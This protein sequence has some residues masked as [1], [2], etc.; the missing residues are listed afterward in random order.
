MAL[1]INVVR[2]TPLALHRATLL[3]FLAK[4]PLAS[5][6][7]MAHPL[8]I[9][10]PLHLSEG[11]LTYRVKLRHRPEVSVTGCAYLL[12]LKSFQEIDTDRF[13]VA[14]YG[15]LQSLLF[16]Q[17][18]ESI[19]EE[20][21][22]IRLVD[23]N[24][25]IEWHALAAYAEYALSHLPFTVG[26][27]VSDGAFHVHLQPVAEL[28]AA[29]ISLHLT[30]AD[31]AKDVAGMFQRQGHFLAQE[32]LKD[33]FLANLADVL[34]ALT[35][36]EKAAAILHNQ[37]LLAEQAEPTP[38]RTIS[39]CMIV[40]NEAEHL[41]ACLASV[42]G[43]VDEIIVVDTGSTD[44]TIQIAQ[45]FGAKVIEVPWQEDFAAARNVSL[46]HATSDWILVLDADEKLTCHH[47]ILRRLTTATGQ[48]IHPFAFNVQINNLDKAGTFEGITSH[49]AP[50]LFKRSFGLQY[51]GIIHEQLLKDGQPILLASA[52]QLTILHTGYTQA[53]MQGK[54][55]RNLPLLSRAAQA[56]PSNPFVHFNL[57]NTYR[58][59]GRIEEAVTAYRTCLAC[60]D[61][62][63]PPHYLGQVY[64]CLSGS[65]LDQKDYAGAFGLC[66]N[67]H[68]MAHDYAEHWLHAGWACLALQMYPEAVGAFQ[69]A[70]QTKGMIGDQSASTWK[71]W[72]GL[73]Q[74]Y[75]A[76]GDKDRAL[77]ALRKA[78]GIARN[79]PDVRAAS[80]RVQRLLSAV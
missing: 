20:R 57:G 52:P 29:P 62:E 11:S 27:S 53:N 18:E 7:P 73:M 12:D 72:L 34:L 22:A 10:E 44:D 23:M 60:V 51:Q 41:P 3:S 67:A 4:E 43:V 77:V 54:Y 58:E 79:H 46:S 19:L 33:C 64:V 65:L 21:E 69:R 40:R 36:V 55:E 31:L 80:A 74:A 9:W 71:P 66:Q 45:S 28:A 37:A 25:Q 24:G 56:D 17:V 63:N 70:Q 13:T 2:K 16:W 32:A 15:V 68:P 26:T 47:E 75:E 48:P 59:S 38:N 61:M 50:R 8:F 5:Y 76:V 39:L 78:E 1:K 42:T 14:F 35:S 49:M 30:Q 6:F